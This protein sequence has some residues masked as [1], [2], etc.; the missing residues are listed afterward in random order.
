[1]IFADSKFIFLKQMIEYSDKFAA[2]IDS[3]HNFVGFDNLPVVDFVGLHK[4][5]YVDFVG[6]YNFADAEFA[7]VDFSDLDNLLTQISFVLIILLLLILL[8]LIN[9][10]MQISLVL[11]IFLLQIVLV[12]NLRHN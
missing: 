2:D 10:L 7:E 6:L 5:I 11:M 8:I 4:F 12:E 3:L 1:V 9:L